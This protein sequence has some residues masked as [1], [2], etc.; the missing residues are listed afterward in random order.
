MAQL[1]RDALFREIFSASPDAV[2]VIDANHCIILASPAVTILFGYAPE[3]LLGQSID[4]L[5]PDG[6]R[7]THGGHLRE[8]YASPHALEN[9]RWLRTRRAPSRRS[10]IPH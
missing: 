9:G 8:F 2:L 10:R 4:V 7:D 3:E 6:R 1:D 5:V